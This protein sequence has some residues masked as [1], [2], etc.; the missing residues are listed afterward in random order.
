[1][2]K[3]S[4][5]HG[6]VVHEVISYRQNKWLEK[7]ISFITEKRGRATSVFEKTLSKLPN[8]AFLN[9]GKQLKCLEIE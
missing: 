2:L 7:Y 4:V 5:R 1:M 8:I 9:S 3:F 6:I